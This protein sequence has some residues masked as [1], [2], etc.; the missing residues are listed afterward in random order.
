MGV[1]LRVEGPAGVLAEGGGDDPL[2]VEDADL[3]V[4][5]VPG[6]GVPFDPVRHRGDGGVVRVDNPRAHGVIAEGVQ[7]RDRLRRGAGD[8]VAAHGPLRVPR[9]E[10]ATG[11]RVE[12]IHECEEVVLVDWSVEPELLGAAT[13]PA[14]RWLAAVEVVVEL[15]LD[16]VA[17]GLGAGEGGRAGGHGALTAES[18]HSSVSG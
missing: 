6:V 1:E 5:P 10:E 9:A 8:V 16:V 12:A 7:H 17:A 4:D 15:V 11:A 13:K 3:A 14:A 18:V 2:G